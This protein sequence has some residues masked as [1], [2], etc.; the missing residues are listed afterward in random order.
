MEVAETSIGHDR[1]RKAALYATAGI[2]E[3]WVIDLTTGVVLV[4]ADPAHSSY[5]TSAV[6]E[7]GQTLIPRSFADVSVAV[8][9]VLGEA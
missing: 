5:R 7:R 4:L 6:A 1:R 8:S 2:P 3:Y 9:E